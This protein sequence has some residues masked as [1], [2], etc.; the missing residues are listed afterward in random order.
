MRNIDEVGSDNRLIYEDESYAVIGAA[1]DVYYRLGCGFLEPVYQEALA[2]EFGLRQI[3]F[4]AQT[5]LTIK[6]KD[7]ILRK[8]YR[9]DFLC[10]EKIVVEIKAQTALIGVDWA[11]L[12]NYMKASSYRV[13][14]LFNFGS[15][16]TLE[17]KRLV[18]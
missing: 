14:L 18:I 10:F 2:Y 9:A 8:T 13:G 3:P 17:K 5:R 6:Y 7:H 16:R 4:R 1:M 15:E 12:L 11:Q